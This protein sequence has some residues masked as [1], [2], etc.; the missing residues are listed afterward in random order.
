MLS[1]DE[2]VLAAQA[3]GLDK[4]SVEAGSARSYESYTGAGSPFA[5]MAVSLMRQ[6]IRRTRR[7]ERG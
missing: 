2:S 3:V 6:Y 1:L 5:P 4:Q 7:F